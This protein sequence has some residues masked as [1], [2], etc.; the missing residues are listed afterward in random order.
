MFFLKIILKQS[1]MAVDLLS[2]EFIEKTLSKNQL[3]VWEYLQKVIEAA[4]LE[5]AQNAGIARPIVNQVV[6]KL[7]KLKRVERI[8]LGRS[9]T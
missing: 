3:Y 7:I 2:E 5:I 4:P 6:N 1:E 9:T 8:G